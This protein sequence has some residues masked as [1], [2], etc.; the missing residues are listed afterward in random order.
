M[1]R[2]KTLVFEMEAIFLLSSTG[3]FVRMPDGF[4]GERVWFMD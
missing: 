3:F 4:Q 1:E 2:Y